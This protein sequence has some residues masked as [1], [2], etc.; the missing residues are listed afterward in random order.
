MLKQRT[1][2]LKGVNST[3]TWVMDQDFLS[4]KFRFCL[5]RLTRIAHTGGNTRDCD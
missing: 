4:R 2:H 3:Q 1:H 5:T